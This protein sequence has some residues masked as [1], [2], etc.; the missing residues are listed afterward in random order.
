MNYGDLRPVHRRCER[1]RP[2]IV[3]NGRRR[4]VG[5]RAA[6]AE[7]KDRTRE[8]TNLEKTGAFMVTPPLA[9]HAMD[10]SDS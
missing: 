5:S 1:K 8:E 9:A 4:S 3:E 10:G 7:A 2:P 6:G